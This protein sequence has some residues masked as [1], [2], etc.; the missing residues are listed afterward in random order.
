M[1]PDT[2]Q[3]E[4]FHP[5]ADADP[6][7]LRGI[8]PRVADLSG[9]TIGLFATTFKHSSTPMLKV[10][11]RKLKERYPT[12]RFSWFEWP[13]NLEVAATGDSSKFKEWVK[14]VDTVVAAVGD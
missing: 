9:K 7:P 14:G 1:S 10:V 12:A 3:Y 6:I 5:W 2:N 11:E 13:Y 4:V 8:T